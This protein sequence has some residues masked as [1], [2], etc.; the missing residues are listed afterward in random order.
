MSWEDKCVHSFLTSILL[1]YAFCFSLMWFKFLHVYVIESVH[2]FR[3]TTDITHNHSACLSCSALTFFQPQNPEIL[4]LE[5]NR[6]DL[7]LLLSRWHKCAYRTT[8]T[9]QM[10]KL[11][12]GQPFVRFYLLINWDIIYLMFC[13]ILPQDAYVSNCVLSCHPKE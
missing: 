5:A 9:D 1:N 11:C 4:R 6:N 2:L 7:I 3:K 12:W 10:W 8:M 13:F